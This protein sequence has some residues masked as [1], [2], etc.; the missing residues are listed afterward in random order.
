MT[1]ALDRVEFKKPV[2]LGDVVSFYASTIR[3]GTSSVTVRV[4]VEAERYLTGQAVAVTEAV[5]TLVSVDAE[6]KPIP[7][8]SPPTAAMSAP[9]G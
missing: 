2:H 9:P 1:V 5:L 6:G 7:F 4:E 3:T 8:T